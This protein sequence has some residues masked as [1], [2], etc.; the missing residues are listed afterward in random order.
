MKLVNKFRGSRTWTCVEIPPGG[1]LIYPQSLR[2][3]TEIRG[4]NDRFAITTW[5]GSGFD[6]RK[7]YFENPN[8]VKIFEDYLQS[9]EIS[10]IRKLWEDCKNSGI[11]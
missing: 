11:A 6:I 8:D 4:S 3:W 5:Y 7:I 9:P 1:D 10:A 2:R